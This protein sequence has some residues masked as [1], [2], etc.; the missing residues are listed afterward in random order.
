MA[1]AAVVRKKGIAADGSA[2]GRRMAT[3]GGSAVQTTH[4]A[5][6]EQLVWLAES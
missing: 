2:S 3:L 5:Q 1:L 6:A 4:A